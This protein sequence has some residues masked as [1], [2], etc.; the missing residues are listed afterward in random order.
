M[1][2]IYFTALLGIS[3][4]VF[5]QTGKVGVNT[6]TPSAT[7]DIQPY[8]ENAATTATTAEGLLIPRVSR[9]RA[10]NMGLTPAVSTMIYI[11]SVADGALAG[12]TANVDA[13]GFYY[14]D[15]AVWIKLNPGGGGAEIE[16]LNQMGTAST[17]ASTNTTNSYLNAKLGVGNFSGTTGLA[18]MPA[19]EKF[20]II[21]GDHSYVAEGNN[22]SDAYFY[23]YS[24]TPGNRGSVIFD[25]ARGTAAA[26]LAVQ[27]GDQLGSTYYWSQGTNYMYVDVIRGATAG[28]ATMQYKTAAAANIL[29]INSDASR[30]VTTTGAIYGKIRVV[31][32]LTGFSIASD[33]YAIII[34]ISGAQ[35]IPLPNPTTM[36]GRIIHFRN[37]SASTGIRGTYTFTGFPPV[38]NTTVSASRGV[39]LMSDGTNWYVVSGG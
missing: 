34:N 29:T 30:A 37:G 26:P 14:F 25:R 22:F 1:K 3:S 11:N 2:K 17:K 28:V 21:N 12:T 24:N 23:H 10:A 38:T 9:L 6:S 27:Q 33:D 19:T 18:A 7:L 8:M 32:S 35:N 16:P 5:S 36:P 13:V 4:S 31:T 20:R 15:G 39:T